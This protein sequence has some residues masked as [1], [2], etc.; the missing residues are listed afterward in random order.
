MADSDA[1]DQAAGE[2]A[3]DRPQG[4]PAA[5]AS[6]EAA[7]AATEP[8][9]S[10]RDEQH[11]YYYATA[12]ITERSGIFPKWMMAVVAFFVIFAVVYVMRYWHGANDIEPPRVQ[13]SQQ[14]PASESGQ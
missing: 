10:R 6:A 14:A 12:E 8:E 9:Q 11:N 5:N 4:E 13:H 3:A 1:K 7:A 2:A